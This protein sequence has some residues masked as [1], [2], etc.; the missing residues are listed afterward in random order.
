MLIQPEWAPQARV[1][2]CFAH[3]EQS[4]TM[5]LAVTFLALCWLLNNLVGL[6][7]S[8]LRLQTVR[9]RELEQQL[10]KSAQ[11]EQKLHDE[12]T[13]LKD[14]ISHLQ[15]QLR[16]ATDSETSLQQQLKQS[17]SE[18]ELRDCLIRKSEGDAKKKEEKLQADLKTAAATERNLRQRLTE[19]QQQLKQAEDR[20]RKMHEA[21][22]SLK[23]KAD[24]NKLGKFLFHYKTS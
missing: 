9:K 14:D 7:D 24:Y 3:A 21:V 2:L 4:I 1:P 5:P 18:V 10:K 23:K 8:E 13:G 16:S 20:Q 15:Q 6:S 11:R 12:L 19:L 22:K 17:Q